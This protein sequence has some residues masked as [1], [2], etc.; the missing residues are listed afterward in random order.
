[1]RKDLPIHPPAVA[2]ASE[3]AKVRSLQLA[4][5][6]ETTEQEDGMVDGELASAAG[7]YA[8]AHGPHRKAERATVFNWFWPWPREA[9]GL[10]TPR[11]TLLHAASLIIAEIER[12]DR[13]AAKAKQAQEPVAPA[14]AASHIM[15][16]GSADPMKR[17]GDA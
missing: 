10:S 6:P 13:A 17:E 9:F 8:L 12:L 15:D 1:M 11:A 2:I 14:Q 3:I 4:N 16:G 5:L 7:V